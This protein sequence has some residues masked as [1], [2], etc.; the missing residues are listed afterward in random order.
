[1]ALDSPAPPSQGNIQRAAFDGCDRSSAAMHM[2]AA[3]RAVRATLR[4]AHRW[5]QFTAAAALGRHQQLAS[6]TCSTPMRTRCSASEH[7][8][9]CT[10]PL[11]RGTHAL[12]LS[13]M[14]PWSRMTITRTLL[15]FGGVRSCRDASGKNAA[16]KA[17]ADRSQ[18]LL[19][20]AQHRC[21][22]HSYRRHDYPKQH[23]RTTSQQ[24]VSACPALL[25][26]A[27]LI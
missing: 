12:W 4:P 2:P 17:A 25:V 16:G 18:V 19:H 7:F 26:V 13:A 23:S 3:A 1:M 20:V 11:T 10:L 8:K 27:C 21:C 5:R 22:C 6:S 15:S 14:L 9:L 24:A